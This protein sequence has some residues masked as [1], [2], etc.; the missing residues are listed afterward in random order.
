MNTRW[1]AENE[2][3]NEATLRLSVSSSKKQKGLEAQSWTRLTNTFWV[4][5]AWERHEKK[6]LHAHRI[7]YNHSWLH[8]HAEGWEGKNGKHTHTHTQILCSSRTLHVASC[9]IS[10]LSP[11]SWSQLMHIMFISVALG[12][13]LKTIANWIDGLTLRK[14]PFFS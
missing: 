8:T 13:K 4:W 6:W 14:A 1:K 11:S 2:D 12:W 7:W 10:L 5:L 3:R 9:A